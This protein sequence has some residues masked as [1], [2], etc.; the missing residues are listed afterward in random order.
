MKGFLLRAALLLCAFSTAAIAE[1]LMD[2]CARISDLPPVRFHG[3]LLEEFP[4]IRDPELRLANRLLTIGCYAPAY[5]KIRAHIRANNLSVP[6]R[7]M[8]ARY[9][10]YDGSIE[11]A[12]PHIGGAL[13]ADPDFVS[14]K[15]LLSSM[16]YAQGDIPKMRALLDE[17]EARAAP[18]DLWIY[19]NRLR[20][21]ALEKPSRRVRS[22]LLEIVRHP[23]FPVGAR[24]AAAQAG[25]ELPS[26]TSSEVEEFMWA[27]LE[28]KPSYYTGCS[29]LA[30]AR[31]LSE[32]GGRFEKTRELLESPDAADGGCGR[33]PMARLLLGQAYLMQ[34]AGIF[35]GPA[36]ANEHLID[37]ALFQLEGDLERLR[38]YAR[39][40][41]Q[42]K[43]LKP[44]IDLPP[45]MEPPDGNGR[46]PVCNAI[47]E[48]NVDEARRLL[49]RGADVL[50]KC[51][52]A[53]LMGTVM[54][55]EGKSRE[56]VNRQH[57]ILRVLKFRGAWPTSSE[58]ARCEEH[59]SSFC[60]R[61]LLPTIQH[62]DLVPGWSY[63]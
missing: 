6:G 59:S 33:M 38:I 5:D 41:P 32:V 52:G 18:S 2:V 17:V 45:P 19:L 12:K 16:A 46:T 7:V 25:V 21:E 23:Q 10:W 26:Q 63:R 50:G 34:A 42:E 43:A 39:G 55:M 3:R 24:E 49:F 11:D 48:L 14:A 61:I 22:L 9:A 53:S 40:R 44:F 47:R 36:P 8:M 29:F 1:N 20:L 54:A 56:S 57:F 27:R 60:S 51:D 58:L 28:I 30:L 31:Q 15:V 4:D 62:D 13:H 35:P 37:K